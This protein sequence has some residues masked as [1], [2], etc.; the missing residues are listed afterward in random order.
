MSIE[1]IENI[2]IQHL[3]ALVVEMG[4][5][6]KYDVL[7]PEIKAHINFSKDI[8]SV[9]DL[10]K[11]TGISRPQII[12]VTIFGYD[13]LPVFPTFSAQHHN[14]SDKTTKNGPKVP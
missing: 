9:I 11:E 14:Q 10:S 6:R 2:S 3:K 4:K 13:R 12:E 1:H 5:Q 7:T 8:K